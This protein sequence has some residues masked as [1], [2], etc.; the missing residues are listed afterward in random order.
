MSKGRSL[1]SYNHK[2]E[3]ALLVVALIAMLYGS[4]SDL[5][6]SAATREITG[7]GCKRPIS[8]TV[9]IEALAANRFLATPG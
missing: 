3:C 6:C 9:V 1:N 2:L 8:L 4:P 5:G 7:L